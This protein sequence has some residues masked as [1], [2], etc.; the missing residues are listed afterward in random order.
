MGMMLLERSIKDF[1]IPDAMK[2]MATQYNS[3]KQSNMVSIKYSLNEI[4]ETTS[5]VG[6]TTRVTGKMDMNELDEPHSR[7]RSKSPPKNKYTDQI[8]YKNGF[9]ESK[10]RS[11]SSISERNTSKSHRRLI[12]PEFEAEQLQENILETR[13]FGTIGRVVP[14]PIKNKI[15]NEQV[16][17]EMNEY[18]DQTSKIIKKLHPLEPLKVDIRDSSP[19]QKIN[20][21]S[22]SDFEMTCTKQLDD[23]A[24][25][26]AEDN[27]SDNPITSENTKSPVSSIIPNTTVKYL[28]VESHTK[29][30]PKATIKTTSEQ[31]KSSLNYSDIPMID[32]EIVD[33]I[34]PVPVSVTTTVMKTRTTV[35]PTTPISTHSIPSTNN[36]N[37]TANNTISKRRWFSGGNDDALSGE[38]KNLGASFVIAQPSTEDATPRSRHNSISS[39]KPIHII[40]VSSTKSV[41]PKSNQFSICKTDNNNRTINISSRSRETNPNVSAS[42]SNSTSPH[43]RKALRSAVGS[44]S[45]SFHRTRKS[46]SPCHKRIVRIYASTP[47]G[48]LDNMMSDAQTQ[49]ISPLATG[50]FTDHCVTCYALTGL[51]YR[52]KLDMDSHNITNNNSNP[53]KSCSSLAISKEINIWTGP[54]SAETY[55]LELLLNSEILTDQEVS[56]KPE[57]SLETVTKRQI[58]LLHSDNKIEELSHQVSVLGLR[59]MKNGDETD[60]M[61]WELLGIFIFTFITLMLSLT[62]AFI[63]LDGKPCNFGNFLKHTFD[64]FKRK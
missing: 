23:V 41:G 42:R 26:K 51:Q 55:R 13:L 59:N 62:V 33:E 5:V 61:T 4:V 20:T 60:Y 18:N 3:F 47:F 52:Q 54:D 27:R 46:S 57:C 32:E 16:P 35:S 28:T 29:D 14:V 34:K 40:N 6:I 48:K 36:S 58:T 50:D 11:C 56:I 24:S 21:L 8:Q 45:R 12:K 19:A 25:I 64:F 10:S 39:S 53:Y 38:N 2:E 30:P 22:K 17:F 31:S 63:C 15:I 44:P 37:T 49:M 1:W 9:S 43:K 7:Q